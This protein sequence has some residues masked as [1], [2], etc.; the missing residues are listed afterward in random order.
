MHT[1]SHSVI[2]LPQATQS[3][4]RQAGFELG[5]Q[6][7]DLSAT[8][9]FSVESRAGLSGRGPSPQASRGVRRRSLDVKSSG[10]KMRVLGCGWALTVQSFSWH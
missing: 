5:L 3:E 7:V 2:N 10:E 1:Q 8:D 9:L 6:T 4:N